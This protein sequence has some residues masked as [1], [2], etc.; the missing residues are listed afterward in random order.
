MEPASSNHYD[1]P[2]VVWDETMNGLL[3]A[4]IYKCLYM[5]TFDDTFQLN[6]KAHLTCTQNFCSVNTLTLGKNLHNYMTCMY[7]LYLNS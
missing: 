1:S 6:C 5:P 4:V 7:V 2:G 3:E